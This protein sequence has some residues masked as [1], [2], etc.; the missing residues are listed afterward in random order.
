MANKGECGMKQLPVAVGLLLCEQVIIEKG[1]DN[2]TLV[3]CFRERRAKQIPSEPL[4]FVI[5]AILTNGLGDIAVTVAIQ[6]LDDFRDVAR[7]TKVCRFTDPFGEF[8]CTLNI[9]NIVFPAVGAYQVLLLA[10][11][12][13][14][15]HR[16]FTVKHQG[17]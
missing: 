13:F 4:S 2:I 1:T 12:K 15:A 10:D 9:N 7:F 3:N 5:Y 11:G 8:R 17:E 6:D 16:R 14:V